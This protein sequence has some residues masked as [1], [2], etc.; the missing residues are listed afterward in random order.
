MLQLQNWWWF[1]SVMALDDAQT[2]R[3]PNRLIVVCQIGRL[4][5][6]TVVG[7]YEMLYL[8]WLRGVDIMGISSD[9]MLFHV[10]E[11]DRE[12]ARFGAQPILDRP[13]LPSPLSIPLSEENL[14]PKNTRKWIYS[15]LKL[16]WGKPDIWVRYWC[17]QRKKLLI[18][19][20]EHRTSD[21]QLFFCS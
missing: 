18:E 1:T 19:G 16:V 14:Y 7:L 17:L 3:M 21:K 11:N 10:L 8:W 13:N 2:L 9:C 6:A 20:C 4:G 12:S 15:D 5:D